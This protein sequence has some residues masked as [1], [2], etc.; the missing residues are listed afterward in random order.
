MPGRV[1]VDG[2]S[3]EITAIPKLLN[4]FD[5]KGATVT[6]DAAGCR[7]T[8]ARKICDEGGD[9]I[10]ALKGNHKTLHADVVGY[11]D[12]L[13]CGDIRDMPDDVWETCE[14]RSHGR[15][16]DKTCWF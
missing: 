2:K 9:Y 13:D 6:I 14:E 4:L 11:F 10:L 3:N 5:V 7:K 12:G 16:V 1:A 15:V 8:T